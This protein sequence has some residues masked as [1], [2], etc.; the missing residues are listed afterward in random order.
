LLGTASTKAH[1]EQPHGFDIIRFIEREAMVN[2]GGYDEE[3]ARLD[4]DADPY[5]CRRF[6]TVGVESGLESGLGF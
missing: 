1:L 2:A 5:V 4:G 3:I 6:C